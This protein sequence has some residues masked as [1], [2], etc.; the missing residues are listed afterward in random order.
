LEYQ[1]L[2]SAAAFGAKDDLRVGFFEPR[3]K[4]RIQRAVIAP[5]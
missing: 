2:Y 5:L 1:L 3:Q 4:G